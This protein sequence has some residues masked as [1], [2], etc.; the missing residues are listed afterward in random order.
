MPWKPKTTLQHC[1]TQLLSCSEQT[2]SQRQ[3]QHRARLA[4]G[5][6]TQSHIRFSSN[7]EPYTNR[8][9]EIVL[10]LGIKKAIYFHSCC[11]AWL[12][13]WSGG[14]PHCQVFLVCNVDCWLELDGKWTLLHEC[15]ITER[16]QRTRTWTR[17]S[18]GCWLL[19]GFKHTCVVYRWS[20]TSIVIW[21]DEANTC[22][23]NANKH[24]LSCSQT[25]LNPHCWWKSIWCDSGNKCS[26]TR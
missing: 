3:S 15:N 13:Q 25:H 18:A 17:F 11:S 21:L 1:A 22:V 12:Q 4:R 26:Q 5:I 14:E 23:S 2:S 24:K 8:R 7:Q 6:N 19:P 10:T 20:L 16:R 9:V